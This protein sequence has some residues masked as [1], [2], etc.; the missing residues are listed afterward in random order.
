MSEKPTLQ[1]FI[2]GLLEDI[3][4]NEWVVVEMTIKKTG[5]GKWDVATDED[6]GP[7][8]LKPRIVPK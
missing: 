1:G 4:K 5:E 7:H 8:V 3:P 2:D 6:F